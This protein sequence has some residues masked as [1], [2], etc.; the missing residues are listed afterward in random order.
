MKYKL[1]ERE[2][3]AEWLDFHFYIDKCEDKSGNIIYCLV[4]RALHSGKETY[5]FENSEFITITQISE[6]IKN[7]LMREI[8]IKITNKLLSLKLNIR[9]GFVKY[10][11]Y[12][13][14]IDYHGNNSYFAHLDDF[15]GNYDLLAESI[16]NYLEDLAVDERLNT[17]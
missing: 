2:D 3:Y 13:Q 15:E 17:K 5:L 9:Y 8:E 4:A 1:L 7:F 16:I 11:D 10:S 14:I 6:E 12:F